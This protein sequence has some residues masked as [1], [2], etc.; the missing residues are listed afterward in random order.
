VLVSTSW[1]ICKWVTAAYLRLLDQKDSSKRDN[2]HNCEEICKGS[3]ALPANKKKDGQ[4]YG[5][6]I[7]LFLA[8]IAWNFLIL[9][10]KSHLSI[11]KI[12]KPAPALN[13]AKNNA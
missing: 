4:T 5:M 6:C 11:R 1:R 13:K 9:R 3:K 10:Q 7:L 12:Q 8:L 2:P